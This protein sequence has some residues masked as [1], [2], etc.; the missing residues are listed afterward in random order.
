MGAIGTEVHATSLMFILM[1][2]AADA[3]SKSDR[4]H[5]LVDLKRL[6]KGRFQFQLR[7]P[8][9]QYLVSSLLLV[10]AFPNNLLDGRF[11]F[12]KAHRLLLFDFVVARYRAAG[13]MC[14]VIP[15][16]AAAVAIRFAAPLRDKPRVSWR[17]RAASCRAPV[18]TS[19]YSHHSNDLTPGTVELGKRPAIYKK[20]PRLLPRLTENGETNP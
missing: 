10:I 3:E 17:I 20:L 12:L 5:D 18:L 14:H 16:S 9:R 19:P 4:S 15:N 6:Q 8:F 1:S 13:T 11:P 2:L 7:T